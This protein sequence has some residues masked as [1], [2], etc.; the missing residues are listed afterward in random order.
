[1]NIGLTGSSGVLGNLLKKKLNL[2]KKNLFSGKIENL[3]HVNNWIKIND[4]D[5]IIHLA[6]VVPIKTVNKNKIKALS[7]NYSGT[8]NLINSINNFSKKKIW[9]FYS[10]TS[11]VY[12]FKKSQ[13]YETDKTK[14]ISFY[15]QTK[16]KGER[17]VLN[18]QKMYIACI[19]R[20]FSFTSKN[21]KK[22]FI[23]PSIL[24][25]L[26][27]KS[28]IIIFENLN[29][30]RDFLKLE[31]IVRYIISLLMN[32][33]KGI[34]NICSGKKINLID[35]LLS[36]NKKYKKNITIK[37]NINKTTLFGS[38]KKLIKSISNYKKTDYLDYLLKNY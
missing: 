5:F 27:K 10:S 33:S 37:K 17:Y 34:F 12:N 28:K 1:M 15:G 20:I 32:K 21:Q 13:I 24:S 2:K 22:D 14:P 16:L 4:F 38:N 35:I 3:N 11:H 36:L 26:K 25:K 23:I 9:F 6:A 19:G 31:D 18:K 29:H 8:K 30:E 7:I